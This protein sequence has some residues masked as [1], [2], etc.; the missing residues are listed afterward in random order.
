[1]NGEPNDRGS[2]APHW[3]RMTVFLL[4]KCFLRP[5]TC[6]KTSGCLGL[7][8]Y[9]RH[10]VHRVHRA[11]LARPTD[12][13]PMQCCLSSN[14]SCLCKCNGCAFVAPFN[15]ALSPVNT[16]CWL[17]GLSFPLLPSRSL[18]MFQNS[19][20][21]ENFE[22]CASRASRARIRTSAG[23][24]LISPKSIES[25]VSAMGTP[26]CQPLCPPVSS[27]FEP[28]PNAVP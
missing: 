5:C 6:L 19:P 20:K 3:L 1:M 14:F 25:L 17:I 18:P 4:G 9:P 27:K 22:Y 13:A 10:R 26:T 24:V 11:F 8:L 2:S 7:F 28:S 16:G 15:R 21:R 23:E 12:T